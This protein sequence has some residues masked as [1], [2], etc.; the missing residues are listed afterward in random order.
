MT[1]KSIVMLIVLK[2][3]FYFPRKRN[4]SP[5]QTNL[6][7][8]NNMVTAKVMK[9]QAKFNFGRIGLGWLMN[10]LSNVALAFSFPS[11]LIVGYIEY[12][13][14]WLAAGTF[15]LHSTY[16]LSRKRC[17]GIPSSMVK[18]VDSGHLQSPKNVISLVLTTA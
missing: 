14:E 4:I 6:M 9:T 2:D 5:L 17:E 18:D 8:S 10:P 7:K 11:L 13:M 1:I 3:I 12:G 16:F 15:L